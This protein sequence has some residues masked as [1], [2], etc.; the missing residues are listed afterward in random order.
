MKK[1]AAAIKLEEK[2]D[3]I[4]NL[5]GI[6]I[7]YMLTGQ[8]SLSEEETCTIGQAIKIREINQHEAANS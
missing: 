6:I 2:D 5:A 8:V 4:G 3:L 7:R 1:S